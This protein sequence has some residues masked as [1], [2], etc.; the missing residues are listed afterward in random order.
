MLCSRACPH[1]NQP[2]TLRH[3]GNSLYGS[4]DT[5]ARYDGRWPATATWHEGEFFFFLISC[6]TP[7]CDESEGSYD[8]LSC[9]NVS[10]LS[11]ATRLWQSAENMFALLKDSV[12]KRPSW[13]HDTAGERLNCAVQKVNGFP[14]YIHKLKWAPSECLTQG[15]A[16]IRPSPCP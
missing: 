16:G 15:Y 1:P 4:N 13:Q 12:Y 7:P 3:S 14:N 9:K 6:Y 11:Y 2:S 8:H 10:I 5:F